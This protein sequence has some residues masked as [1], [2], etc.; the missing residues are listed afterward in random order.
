LISILT[1]RDHRAW[2]GHVEQ[3]NVTTVTD[4]T[5]VTCC[6]VL[7]QQF[8]RCDGLSDVIRGTVDVRVVNVHVEADGEWVP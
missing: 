2:I 3:T 8:R 5:T 6:D 7:G 1:D 4:V